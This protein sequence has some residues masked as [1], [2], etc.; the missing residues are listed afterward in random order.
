MFY[1]KSRLFS[2]FFTHR[3][4]FGTGGCF[5][6]FYSTIPE[7]QILFLSDKSPEIIDIELLIIAICFAASKRFPLYK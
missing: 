1:R 4:F 5:F 3:N 2:P 7:T 6:W